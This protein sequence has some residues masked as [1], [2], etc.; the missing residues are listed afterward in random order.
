MGMRKAKC[1]FSKDMEGE[2]ERKITQDIL[3]ILS[4]DVQGFARIVLRSKDLKGI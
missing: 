4:K 2:R 1:V 3:F